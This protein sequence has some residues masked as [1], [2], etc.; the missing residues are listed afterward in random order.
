MLGDRQPEDYPDAAPF[1]ASGEDRRVTRIAAFVEALAAGRRYGLEQAIE[2]AYEAG[3]SREDLLGAVD[4]AR[5]LGGIRALLLVK[6][7]EDV[8]AWYWIAA[9]RLAPAHAS[10]H[11][12]GAVGQ[13]GE[14]GRWIPLD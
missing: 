8:H 11:A 13:M 7:Y 10:A 6:A 1:Q 4:M 14:M 5:A 3:A 12:P 9:R 2:A